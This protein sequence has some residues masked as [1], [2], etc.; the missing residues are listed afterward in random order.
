MA[1]GGEGQNNARILSSYATL[2]IEGTTSSIRR[3]AIQANNFEIKP[4]II[5]MEIRF[6]NQDATIWNIETQLGHIA[7]MVSRR[8]Q[9]GLPSNSEKNLREQLKANTLRSGKELK[10]MPS[11]AKFLK[12]ILANKRKLEEFE[13]MKLNEECSVILQNK[14]PPKLND[15][16]SFSILCIIGNVN[17]NKT[18]CDLEI[19]EEKL[20]RV[21]REYKG[22]IGWSIADIKGVS[23]SI[24]MHKILLDDGYKPIV[25]LERRLNPNMQDVVKKEVI[26][27]L[28]VGI[29]FPIFGSTW[30]SPVQVMPKKGGTTMVPDT[31]LGPGG[32]YWAESSAGTEEGVDKE[33]WTGQNRG[34]GMGSRGNIWKGDMMWE[35][36]S[37]QQP[38]SS[39]TFPMTGATLKCG[40]NLQN[41]AEYTQYTALQEETEMEEDDST[42]K[43]RRFDIA[44]FLISMS[45][46]DLI[47]VKRQ[48][49]VNG[50]FNNLKFLKE[51]MTNSLSSLR[52][53]FMPNFKSDSSSKESWSEGSNDYEELGSKFS[54]EDN[55]NIDEEEED[56]RGEQELNE[57]DKRSTNTPSDKAKFEMKGMG[58]FE[59]VAE[60]GGVNKWRRFDRST[61]SQLGEEESVEMVADSM[62]GLL[63]ASDMGSGEEVGLCKL[64]SKSRTTMDSIENTEEYDLGQRLKPILKGLGPNHEENEEGD[65]DMRAPSDSKS[66]TQVGE[67][68]DLLGI[69]RNE[70]R[71]DHQQICSEIQAKTPSEEAR[72]NER[73]STSREIDKKRRKRRAVSCRSVYQ[74]AIMFGLTGQRRKGRSKSKKKQAEK[75]GILSFL[76]NMSNSVAG[77]SVG[78]SGIENCNRMLKEQR[79]CLK[80]KM[81][82][83]KEALRKW[84]RDST[85]DIERKISNVAAEI[86][87]IDRK[88]EQEQLMEEEIKKRREATITLWEN[89][90]RKESVIQQKSRKTWLAHGDANTKFFHK[91]VKGRWRRN[92]MISI[93]INGVQLKVASRMKDELAGFF[94]EMFKEKQRVRPKLNG[95]CFKQ[96]SQ[97]DN[98]FITG[99]FSESEIKVAVWECD[100]LKA[101]GPD[102]FNF[103][104]IKCEWELIKDDVI[105][106]IQ[107]FHKNNKMVRGLNTS[108][109]VLV[110]KSDNPQKIK[111]CRP[112]SLIGVMYKILAK[113]L[114]NRLKKVL[115]QVVGEQ[116]TAFLSGR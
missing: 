104:F 84:S 58:E 4:A 63:E 94:E 54:A 100:S 48:I 80:E 6:Q 105:R 109:I 11:Y 77:G 106:F 53:D 19:E 107:E 51:E 36:S 67:K 42:S 27:W 62:E 39:P 30:V 18:L 50:V 111:E 33:G 65:K 37:K 60:R 97:E 75:E 115:H 76:P 59:I 69:S 99:P 22:A 28:D 20:L 9:G 23:L 85:L 1:E 95:V 102:G 2:S 16:R 74:K 7:N 91:C 93:H 70:E 98:D 113:L 32:Q 47:S 13:M 83:T 12:E 10:E 34:R 116:Q 87:W 25:Q 86:D 46:M 82:L 89:M 108:F 5:Q 103:K 38:S 72:V 3:P 88:G 66:S 64:D 14:L 43:R 35:C 71:R 73:V 61:Y 96:I 41:L 15:P 31:G 26:K 114:A 44:R 17:F 79:Y 81:K 110:P 55:G 92:E 24:C 52:Y 56:V 78:D 21:L 90:K 57:L 40:Q 8:V 49:K 68:G 112:I 45:I 29:V 101:L